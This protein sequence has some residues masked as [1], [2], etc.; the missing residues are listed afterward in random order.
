MNPDL[1]IDPL[2]DYVAVTNM[3][4]FGNMILGR[5]D[6]RCK[7]IRDMVAA[8]KAQPESV[9]L[10]ILGAGNR[11]TIA[12]I[13]ERTGAKFLVVPFKGATDTLAATLGG[14]VDAHFDTVGNLLGQKGK[15]RG[16]AFGGPTPS[17]QAPSVPSLRQLYNVSSGSWFAVFAPAKTPDRAVQWM[18]EALR[19]AVR[20]PQITQMIE[21]NGNQVVANSQPEFA[22]S[23]RAEVEE[24]RALVK[25]YP[26][27]R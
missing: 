7:D 1:K 5:E 3:F 12:L 26:E 9:K 16:I 23:F 18:A 24:N 11:F 15:L 8:A 6:G 27:I 25:K 14:Q 21:T 20:D 19:G 22:K 4:E 2:N 10:G 13:E 17:P